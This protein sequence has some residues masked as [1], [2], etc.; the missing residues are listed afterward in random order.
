MPK[1]YHSRSKLLVNI[2][3][4][5]VWPRAYDCGRFRSGSAKRPR[6]QLSWLPA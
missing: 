5:W 4:I 1:T 3:A 6:Y 2:M